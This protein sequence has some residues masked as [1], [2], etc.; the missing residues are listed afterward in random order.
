MD[1]RT[2]MLMLAVGSFLYGLLLVV[3]ILKKKQPAKSAFLGIGKD[4]AGGRFS[5]ALL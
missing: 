2:V 3:F 4:A 5:L 1:L